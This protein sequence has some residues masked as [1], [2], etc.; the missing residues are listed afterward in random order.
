MILRWE[1]IHNDPR[2]DA[3]IIYLILS[4]CVYALNILLLSLCVYAL[5]ILLLSLCIYSFHYVFIAFTVCL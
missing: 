3:F 2:P 5:N 1:R 4:L